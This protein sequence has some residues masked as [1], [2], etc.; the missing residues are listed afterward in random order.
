VIEILGFRVSVKCE[1]GKIQWVTAHEANC[2][3]CGALLS[4]EVH[5]SKAPKAEKK[6]EAKPT[7]KKA[8]TKKAE[9]KPAEKET[10]K[11]GFWNK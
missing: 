1:C 7:E 10:K 6:A 5:T 3:E 4:V 8:E 9:A 2:V 11:K